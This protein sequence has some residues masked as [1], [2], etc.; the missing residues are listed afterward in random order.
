MHSKPGAGSEK[1][2]RGFRPHEER[3]KDAAVGTIAQSFQHVSQDAGQEKGGKT[4]KERVI[5]AALGLGTRMGESRCSR[6][7][8]HLCRAKPFQLIHVSK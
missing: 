8:E 5:F 3:N 2:G 1:V 4:P 6:E 7:V